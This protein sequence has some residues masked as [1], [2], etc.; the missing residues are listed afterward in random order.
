MFNVRKGVTL[1]NFSN[2]TKEFLVQAGFTDADDISKLFADYLKE[3]DLD[4]NSKYEDS[5]QISIK[6]NDCKKI[7]YN[8]YIQ[9]DVKMHAIG[10]GIFET[11]TKASKIGNA[12][13]GRSFGVSYGGACS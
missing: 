6:Q 5:V 1:N 4:L 8:R 10:L 13:Y 7:N 9:D 12:R 11:I 2:D 3:N